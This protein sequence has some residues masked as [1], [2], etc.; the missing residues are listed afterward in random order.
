MALPTLQPYY[1]T[2]GNKI[3][4]EQK[5]VAKQTREAD[6]KDRWSRHSCYFHDSDTQSNKQKA[7]TSSKSFQD[8]FVCVYM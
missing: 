2:H 7:W 8:R 5:I 3:Q 4:T 1:T 6:L